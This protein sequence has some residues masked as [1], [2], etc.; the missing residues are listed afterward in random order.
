LPDCERNDVDEA[1]DLEGA[2]EEQPEV[3]EHLREEIPVGREVKQSFP[4]EQSGYVFVTKSSNKGR[5]DGHPK[6]P[7]M[8]PISYFV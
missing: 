8:E 6:P 2:D 1:V 3:L 7:E 4:M 5:Q